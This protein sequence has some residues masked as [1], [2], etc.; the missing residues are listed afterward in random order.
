MAEITNRKASAAE[1]NMREVFIPEDRQN[2]HENTLSITVNG[3][4]YLV[5]RGMIVRVPGEV[6]DILKFKRMTMR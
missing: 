5:K 6:Y 2:P 4:T 1:K 3:K